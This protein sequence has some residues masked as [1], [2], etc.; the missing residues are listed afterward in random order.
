MPAPPRS[1]TRPFLLGELA[2]VAFLL[3]GYDRVA[4]V[5]N[6]HAAAAV[7]HGTAVLAV[8]RTLHLA[9]ESSFNRLLAAQVALGR[10][11]AVYY[12]FAHGVVTFGALLMVY[13]FYAGTYRRAR[14]ALLAVN[15]IGLAI[16]LLFPVAPPRL[17]PGGGFVDVVAGSGT[18]GAWEA[19]SSGVAEHAAKFAA[20]P[21]LHVA[22][23]LWV[24]RVVWVVSRSA[25]FRGLVGLHVGVTIAIVVSTGNHY[26]LDVAAGAA[27]AELAWWLA[28]VPWRAVTLAGLR[29]LPAVPLSGRG[30]AL[31]PAR[32]AEPEPASASAP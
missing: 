27:L 13:V 24:L 16:F 29:L 8:E 5:G 4:S 19:A 23:A 26:V 15:G 25:W 32:A 18:W 22:W 28:A 3:F 12:D 2:L 9:V 6:V 14:T 1:S 11:L 31:A 7:R 30:A 21:S 10:V 20:M 17:L